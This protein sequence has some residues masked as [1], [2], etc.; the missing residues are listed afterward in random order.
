MQLGNKLKI[1]Q[2]SHKK[3]IK[4]NYVP[5]SQSFLKPLQN[6]IGPTTH[7]SQDISVLCMQ[8]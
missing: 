7:I 6:C 2:P 3:I 1:M 5:S 4:K 8:D